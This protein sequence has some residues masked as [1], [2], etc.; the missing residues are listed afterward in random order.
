MDVNKAAAK[1]SEQ[2]TAPILLIMTETH[3]DSNHI[4]PVSDS[5]DSDEGANDKKN[6]E[7]NS[8]SKT[9][10][11]NDD[12]SSQSVHQPHGKKLSGKKRDVSKLSDLAEQ[13]PQKKSHPIFTQN[14]RG[15]CIAAS[16]FFSN[17]GGGLSQQQLTRQIDSDVMQNLFGPLQ[18]SILGRRS[19]MASIP[20]LLDSMRME[21]EKQVNRRMSL[22]TAASLLGDPT[23]Q[24]QEKLSQPFLAP[25]ILA[26]MFDPSSHSRRD[27]MG[28]IMSRRCSLLGD[29][30]LFEGRRGSMSSLLPTVDIPE[31]KHEDLVKGMNTSRRDSLLAVASLINSFENTNSGSLP[32]TSAFLNDVSAAD[33]RNSLSFLMNNHNQIDKSSELDKEKA[34]SQRR[35]SLM[36]LA[37]LYTSLEGPR[38]NLSTTEGIVASNGDN[39]IQSL[40]SSLIQE[41]ISQAFDPLYLSMQATKESQI[42]IHDWDRKMGLRKSHSQTMRNSARSRE[43]LINVMVDKTGIHRAAAK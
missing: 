2:I 31:A 28:S 5:S 36:D 20:D 10:V 25:S 27:S 4:A 6:K 30:S 33:R 22:L 17:Y 39:L 1:T 18:E 34:K 26:G 13:Q 35:G 21:D 37:R 15:S 24:Q 40:R 23:L 43:N 42:R 11:A 12:Q 19:S 32:N 9:T 7:L 29:M 3:C 8:E 38:R 14:R 41:K 16:N